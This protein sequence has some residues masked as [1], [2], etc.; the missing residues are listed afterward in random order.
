MAIYHCS[1]KL[2]GRSGG[3]SAVASA[4]YRSGEKLLNEETGITHDFTRKGGVVMSEILLPANAPDRYHDRQ[5]LWNEVQKVEKRSDAQLAR[6]VE[7]ALP[8]ELTRTQQIECVRNYIH[9]NFT[10]KGMI[11]D[12][13]LHDK[14]D[15]NPHAHI[16]LSVRA[17]DKNEKWTTKQRSV[18]ANARDDKGKP[19]YDPALPSYNPKD[20][21]HTSRFR[22]PALDENGNQKTRER[23]GKGT[24][25]LWE[26][27][28]IPAND[29]NDHSKAEEWRKSWA[30]HC[31]RYLEPD[32]QI[33]HRSY[34][35]QGLDIEPTIHEGVT[36]RQMEQRGDISDRCEINRGIKERNTLRR[37][38]K[39]TFAELTAFIIEK[40]REI[41]A[42]YTDI[43]RH[44]GNAEKAG[45]NGTDVG[46]T[47]ERD[48][49]TGTKTFNADAG[50]IGQQGTD[51]AGAGNSQAV[52]TGALRR[53]QEAF[54]DEGR[55]GRIL[56]LKRGLSSRKPSIEQ[57]AHIIGNTESK[58]ADTDRQLEEL[59]KIKREKER[60][61][62]ERIQKL[63]E[64]R[65]A[66]RY[67][68]GTGGREQGS[69]TADNGLTS[70][71]DDISAFLDS[72]NLKEQDSRTGRRD[73]EFERMDREAERRRFDTKRQREAESRKQQAHKRNGI[74]R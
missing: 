13:A 26:R 54:A 32:R 3:R 11:A 64:R 19:I 44:F 33:D 2:I 65:R 47:A 21:E 36:A 31:N 68:D 15:G 6:E 70:A 29:W 14:G 48:R 23:K 71:V 62:D 22:I 67:G 61:R 38:L 72:I 40:A 46:R 16:M 30:E 50:A 58:I 37:K 1:I 53:E 7:A 41:Y 25:Y 20:R 74:S 42:R 49:R 52:S 35:R 28:S 45:R 39:Q 63:R 5:T 34:E 12:W 4:A 73:S 17:I 57:S 27:I 55:T 56:E 69:A 51:Y 8:S 24:E 9:D 60:E 66:D 10:S 59:I 18:F 43:E